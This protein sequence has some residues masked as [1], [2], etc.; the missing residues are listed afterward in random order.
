MRT[1]HL[2][3]VL[4]GLAIVGL[5]M[6]AAAQQKPSPQPKLATSARAAAA[7]SVVVYK[8]ASCGCC[9]LWVE[10]LKGNGFQ[11]EAHNVDDAKLRS[12]GAEAGVTN[13]LSSCHTAKVGGYIV[14]GHV[15]AA[16]IHRLLKE[17]PAIAGIAAPGMPMGSPGMEQGGVKQPYDVI[18]F[19]KD[20]KKTVFAKHR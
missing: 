2:T 12:I 8:S 1:R 7:N 20:G 9:S 11:V 10:H 6:G 5:T 4:A 15:P 18:A 17:K 19:T 13:D 3:A 14:E 16:D